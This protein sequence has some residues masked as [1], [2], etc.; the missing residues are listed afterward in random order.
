MFSFGIL[1]ISDNTYLLSLYTLLSE[2]RHP[3]CLKL[4]Q[5]D[6]IRYNTVVSA[7]R[8]DVMWS[9]FV[10]YNTTRYDTKPHHSRHT[11]LYDIE[12]YGCMKY[13][14]THRTII[15]TSY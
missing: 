15:N 3:N 6:T 2:Q 1:L 4:Q 12:N 13:L 9:D 8:C 7:V 11:I 14:L 10:E 5:Y